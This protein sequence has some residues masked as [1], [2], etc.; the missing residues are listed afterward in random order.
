M[1]GRL[2]RPEP[3]DPEAVRANEGFERITGYG[4]DE[5]LG[6][7]CRFLQGE[8]TDPET[9]DRL[10][11][12]IDA[13]ESAAAELLNYRADGSP[14]WNQ[15]RLNPVENDDG[16]LT[17]YLGFQTDVTERKRSEQ[18][19]RLLNRVLRHNL[20]NDL[21]VLLGVGSHLQSG[22]VTEDVS[23]LGARIE[24]T[25][26]QREVGKG[27]ES[28][29]PGAEPNEA[30]DGDEPRVKGNLDK[31]S[32]TA[33]PTSEAPFQDT[34]ALEQCPSCDCETVVSTEVESY[35]EE[36]GLILRNGKVERSH[37]ND[38]ARF[39]AQMSFYDLDDLN[40]QM[41]AYLKRSNRIPSSS[42][43]WLSPVQKRN[44]FN[45]KKRNVKRLFSLLRL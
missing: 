8:A 30:T 42:L 2:R 45:K 37:R 28:T 6:R 35:C 22:S 32:L 14:F 34:R 33:E 27:G 43:K 39:Y 24:R 3:L 31:P 20:R 5:M 13:G 9:V 12:G 1:T 23:E 4:A 11:T 10:R 17:H 38:N 40:H 25:A 21:N 41:K 26:K 19:V 7:N 36:C 29:A 16:D 15:V 18:L 44:T